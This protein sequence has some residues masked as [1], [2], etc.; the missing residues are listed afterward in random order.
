VLKI[1]ILAVTPRVPY[2]VISN[3]HGKGALPGEFPEGPKPESDAGANDPSKFHNVSVFTP[4]R[5]TAR[6]QWE[7]VLKNQRG[8]E[9][10]FPTAPFM[11]VMGVAAD[12]NELVH[13]VPPGVFGGNMDVKDLGVGTTVYLP[14]FVSGANFYAGDP[15][16]SQ[17]NGEVA[18]TA[19]EHSMRA[20]FRF[21]LLKKGDTRIPSSS[22]TLV[23]PFGETKEYWVAIGLHP[24]LN[25]AMKDAVR[26]SVRFLSEVLGM[27]RAIAYAYLSAATDFNVSQVV[28][29][30]KGIH[31]LIRKSDFK[32]ARAAARH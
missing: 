17:G 18:L 16:M 25:E 26:E 1:D 24:D 23:K 4:I 8:A 11:G 7:G 29:R 22:G 2:G 21:T 19:L 27:D 6:G 13:S 30:T 10:T 14:V 12:T 20:T 31:S 32:K 3:R 5:R 15:H 28:D 9:V